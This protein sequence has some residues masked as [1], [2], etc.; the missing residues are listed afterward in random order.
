MRRSVKTS[1][2]KQTANISDGRVRTALAACAM[3]CRKSASSSRSK[4]GSRIMNA[5]TA[6]APHTPAVTA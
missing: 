6:A 2:E 5:T 1:T 4:A 3:P